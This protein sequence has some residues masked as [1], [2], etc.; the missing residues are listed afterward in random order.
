MADV[1]L[2]RS[3]PFSIVQVSSR[4]LNLVGKGRRR[5]MLKG[6]PRLLLKFTL[7]RRGSGSNTFHG[8]GHGDS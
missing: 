2:S 6:S 8:F 1:A 5:K 3:R 4:R 7:S